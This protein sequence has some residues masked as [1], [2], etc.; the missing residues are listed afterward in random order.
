[1]NHLTPLRRA[2]AVAIALLA[3]LLLAAHA[4]SAQALAG[5]WGSSLYRAE[6]TLSGTSVSGT[7]TS[8]ADPK[9]PPG[10][11][12]GRLEKDG[13]TLTAEWTFSVGAET[14][15]FSTWLALGDRDD[16][17]VGYRWSGDGEPTAFALHRAINGQVPVTGTDEAGAVVGAPPAPA[18]QPQAGQAGGAFDARAIAGEWSWVD[19]QRLVISADGRLEVWKGAS[20]INTATWTCTDPAQL[21]YVFRHASGGWVDTVTLSADGNG[22]QGTNNLGN[23]VRGE[24]VRGVSP[25]PAPGSA[26]AG[27][28][29]GVAAA[30]PA[31]PPVA[32][33]PPATAAPAQSP[34]AAGS[35]APALPPQPKAPGY[36]K[37]VEAIWVEPPD[38]VP[39]RGHWAVYPVRLTPDGNSVTAICRVLDP[40]RGSRTDVEEHHVWTWTPPPVTLVP[41]EWFPMRIELDAKLVFSRVGPYE[42]GGKFDAGFGPSMPTTSGQ[43]D[44]GGDT[45]VPGGGRGTLQ[46]GGEFGVH[47]Q[48]HFTKDSFVLVP[49][50]GAYEDPKRPGRISFRAGGVYSFGWNTRYEYVWMDGAPPADRGGPAGGAASHGTPVGQPMGGDPALGGWSWSAPGWTVILR[51]DG[52]VDSYS[53]AERNVGTWKLV[54]ANPRRYEIR[55][56]RGASVDTLTLSADGQR[57]EG[58][59]QGKARVSAARIR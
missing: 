52:R 54:S 23:T 32:A 22:L 39:G 3:G 41:G 51:A 28:T 11:I 56:V 5:L 4:A 2:R 16:V 9:A 42:Y 48:G 35:P 44:N 34:A 8:L 30:A 17:L 6:L 53:A 49:R 1:M 12:A 45:Q 7:F 57:L 20:R 55:W 29:T 50:K 46:R 27:K 13:R 33:G 31:S 38:R 40:A 21:R 58:A 37:F 24:R 26:P 10:R 25:V 15:A 36:W 14:A 18:G 19:G 47:G 43:Y 59:N